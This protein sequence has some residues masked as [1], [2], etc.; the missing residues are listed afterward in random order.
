MAVV[1]QTELGVAVVWNL[2][3]EISQPVSQREE[4]GTPLPSPTV[5]A[6]DSWRECVSRRHSEGV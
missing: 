5:W 2:V 3:L 4:D 1:W 6:T